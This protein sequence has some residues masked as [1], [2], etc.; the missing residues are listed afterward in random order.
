MRTL[1]CNNDADAR[2]FVLAKCVAFSAAAGPEAT[3]ALCEIID[4]MTVELVER[5]QART[6]SA[7]PLLLTDDVL[8]NTAYASFLGAEG[9]KAW[10]AA[11]AASRSRILAQ[12]YTVS[13]IGQLAEN[14]KAA[15][16]QLSDADLRTMREAAEALD[17]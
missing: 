17:A 13:F 15:D 16:L 2:L 14:A 7:A 9:A 12:D 6:S 11:L 8:R 10:Y 5:G 3:R 1:R 4:G